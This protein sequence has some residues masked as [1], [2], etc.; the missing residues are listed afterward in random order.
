MKHTLDPSCVL[1]QRHV[2][3]TE[4]IKSHKIMHDM[5]LL[6]HF[7]FVVRTVHKINVNNVI[8]KM[9]ATLSLLHDSQIQTN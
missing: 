1:H 5:F 6:F 3:W 4:W 9:F 7:Y 2:A 8:L